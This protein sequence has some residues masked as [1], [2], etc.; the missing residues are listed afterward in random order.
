VYW[1]DD[2]TGDKCIMGTR[3]HD[4]SGAIE[5]NK[6]RIGTD[7]AP[8]AS[9]LELPIIFPNPLLAA[10][11]PKAYVRL[12]MPVENHVA[13]RLFNSLG[14]LV[15]TLHDGRLTAGSYDFVLDANRKDLPSGV[16]YLAMISG[17]Q[18]SVRTLQI[19]R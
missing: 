14:R 6:R 17:K 2:R 12:L 15:E 9:S 13:L 7:K 16:Y 4:E 10:N 1:F 8:V 5:W 11:T 3:F 19:I 18:S